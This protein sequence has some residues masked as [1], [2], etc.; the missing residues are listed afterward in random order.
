[1]PFGKVVVDESVV[2][3]VLP[4]LATCGELE[5]PHAAV[6]NAANTATAA[7]PPEHRYRIVI[8]RLPVARSSGGVIGQRG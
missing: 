3:S 1:L 8:S 2:P 6:P 4:K 7:S 5:P